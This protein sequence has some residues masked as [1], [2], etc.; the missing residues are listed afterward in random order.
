M[1]N[2]IRAA[3]LTYTTRR[4]FWLSAG[5]WLFLVI[6]AAFARAPEA[7]LMILFA[8][9]ILG[10]LLVQHVASQFANP[11]ARLLPRFAAAHLLVAGAMAVAMVAVP[12][13]MV[14]PG[15]AGSGFFMA[16]FG[17][18]L[19]ALGAWS[20]YRGD[21]VLS[22]VMFA[23]VL[24]GI[25]AIQYVAE[26]IPAYLVRGN[27]IVSLAALGIGLV[28]LG[29]LGMR[30]RRLS[31]GMPEY[32]RRAF[33]LPPD[34]K[35]REGKRAWRQWEGQQ[36]SRSKAKGWLHDTQFRLLLRR[37]DATGS[38]RRF[39]L[40]RITA[41][42]YGPFGAPLLFVNALAIVW[43]SGWVE[44]SP[45]SSPTEMI[46]YWALFAIFMG[47]NL[48]ATSWLAHWPY[49]AR[50][51]LYPLSRK[52]FVRDLIGTSA[53]DT[54]ALAAG[55]Y[56]GILVGLA[57]FRSQEPIFP[58]ALSYVATTLP[59]F[60]VACLSTLWLASL[61]SLWLA[62]CG[63]L[64]V[65]VLSLAMVLAASAATEQLSRPASLTLVVVMTAAVVAGLYWV[66]FRRWCRVDLD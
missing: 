55:W 19:L 50:E 63:I 59:A 32:S 34:S 11:R 6:I 48:L 51:L 10:T 36:I 58:I 61:R 39:L 31:E 28:G 60:L 46:S 47:V 57:L 30:L 41:G 2:R 53:F 20:F 5:L 49:L 27:P 17:L 35:S 8:N 15:D 3:L 29:T 64:F 18:A 65:G 14:A 16:G 52:D 37:A 24:A 66:T 40:R 9:A 43:W 1:A 4:D 56:G 21:T 45:G 44:R 33:T 22:R 25:I 26:G 23:L 42:F 12:A 62:V 38:L 54:A 13:G 7:L